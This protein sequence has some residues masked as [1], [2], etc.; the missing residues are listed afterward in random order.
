MEETGHCW[1]AVCSF[2]LDHGFS[3]IVLTPI[4][5]NAW[6]KG[7]EIRKR[8]TAAI[9]ASVSQS[10]QFGSSGTSI[11]SVAL[12]IYVEPYSKPLL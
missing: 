5:T 10:G 7:I 9:D 11:L 2:L 3:V 6:R 12:R 8:K 4:Q 1:L